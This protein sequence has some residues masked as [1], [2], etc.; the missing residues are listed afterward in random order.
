MATPDC[1]RMSFFFALGFFREHHDERKHE[2]NAECNQVIFDIRNHLHYIIHID[3]QHNFLP[4]SFQV[5]FFFGIGSR[6][7]TVN[8]L[9][10]YFTVMVPPCCRAAVYTPHRQSR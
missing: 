10:S 5:V 3:G 8:Q 2:D 7:R 9:F 1:A 6:M 4:S